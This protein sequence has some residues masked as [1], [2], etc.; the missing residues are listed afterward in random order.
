MQE[1]ESQRLGR[2][3][4][5]HAARLALYARNWLERGEAEDAVQEVFLRLVSRPVALANEKAWLFAAVR[6]AAIGARRS[7][8]RRSRREKEA[9]EAQSGWFEP[10]AGDLI[11]AV[12]AQESL[13]RIAEELREVILLR[14]WG[15]LT[16]AEISQVTGQPLSTLFSRYKLGL[17]EIRKLME[18]S[19][20]TKK[21]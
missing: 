11:D 2:W 6:N 17:G 10:K 12:A 15:G 3:F 13:G 14:I 1:S 21:I 19:C 7:R 5:A 20:R 9:V 16:F 18:L 8:E 4:D